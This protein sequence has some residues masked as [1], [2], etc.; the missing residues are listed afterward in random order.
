MNLSLCTPVNPRIQMDMRYAG[1]NNHFGYP[2]YPS[3]EC[4]VVAEVAEQLSKVQKM[5]ESQG[6]GLK[7]FD[8]YRPYHLFTCVG[9]VDLGPTIPDFYLLE[10]NCGHSRGTAVDVS[11]V[12][13]DG[14]YLDMGSN[15]GCTSA[16]A[17]RDCNTLRANVYHNRCLLE[18]AMTRHGFIS[19]PGNWW[20]YDYGSCSLYPL[21]DVSFWEIN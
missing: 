3:A 6:Y 19:T 7:V 10:D 12:C 5:L 4:F 14:G 11:L 8:A 21:L 17:S 16:S 1:Y 9:Y 2:I 15:F 13:E 18:R 20:H